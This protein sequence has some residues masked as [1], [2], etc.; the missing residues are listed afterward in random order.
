MLGLQGN[1]T[2]L[3]RPPKNWKA[4]WRNKTRL[5]MTGWFMVMLLQRLVQPELRHPVQLPLWTVLQCVLLQ[6]P[7]SSAAYSNPAQ[8]PP[9]TPAPLPTP[10][11]AP[12]PTPSNAPLPTPTEA[13]LPTPSDSAATP[14]PTPTKAPLPT[15]SDSAGTPV[16]TQSPSSARTTA[17]PDPP[18]TSA[19]GTAS[20]ESTSSLSRSMHCLQILVEP[21]HHPRTFD[22][23]MLPRHPHVQLLARQNLR[24]QLRRC[25]MA[26]WMWTCPVSRLLS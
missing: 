16:P 10:T 14:L 20:T 12:L 21:R 18:P 17:I 7:P 22:S 25:G 5:G 11:N 13:P 3:F 9:P 23:S 2:L 1:M 6:Q 15:P 24:N 19:P 4:F 8:V 26:C